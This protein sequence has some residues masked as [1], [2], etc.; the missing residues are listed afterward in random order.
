[1]LTEI[2]DTSVY[3]THI[4]YILHHTYTNSYTLLHT[5]HSLY[6]IM[7]MQKQ[8][9]SDV[10][11]AVHFLPCVYLYIYY[12]S[13][14]GYQ[15]YYI[16]YIILMQTKFTHYKIMAY[17]TFTI[18]HAYTEV[19]IILFVTFE[20]IFPLIYITHILYILHQAHENSRETST[21]IIHILYILYIHVYYK[22]FISCPCK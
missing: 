13:T 19:E 20:Y 9:R 1:M 7:L 5:M 18:Y 11:L 2:A 12:Q 4:L 10:L 8:H 3:I 16:S 15:I 22:F 21:Y 6:Y 17:Y 14:N